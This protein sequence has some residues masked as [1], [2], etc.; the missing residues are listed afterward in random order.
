MLYIMRHGKTDWNTAYRL[1]GQ[2]DTDLNAEGVRM[3]REATSAYKD[4]HFDVCYCS[5]LKRAR[6][7]A[8]LVLEGR[9]VPIII[10]ERLK[11]M[12]FG[13]YEGFANTYH[14][15]DCPMYAFFKHPEA[16]KAP[17]GAESMEELFART[18]EFLQEVALPQVEAGK[19]VL[20]I[21]HGAMNSSIVCQ[22]K[23]RTLA[24][25]WAD[26][27]PNCKLQTLIGG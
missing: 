8:Q 7:T 5:P 26:P 11:E 12:A 16:Y 22:V 15:P 19:D 24:E 6:E 13:I 9:E 21:G 1:Q 4:V 27:I 3:A 25:F 20:I 23:K 14:F 18:G 10:D 2:T 17:L